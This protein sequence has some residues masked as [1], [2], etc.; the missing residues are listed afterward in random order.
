MF[1]KKYDPNE[2]L[3]LLSGQD[4]AL[5]SLEKTTYTDF[6]VYNGQSIELTFGRAYALYRINWDYGI[7]D[8]TYSIHGRE[9]KDLSFGIGETVE[10]IDDN[11]SIGHSLRI[12]PDGKKFIFAF[13]EIPTF[14]SGDRVWDSVRH[15]ALY[16]D[17]KGVNLIHCQHGYQIPRI[18]IYIG[19]N[20]IAPGFSKWLNYIDCHDFNNPD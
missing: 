13:E 16:C 15:V 5:R 19:L 10:K 17:D 1:E 18:E 6:P 8:C 20:K 9:F 11:D 14:D 7:S 2:D 4:V 3:V 12:Y